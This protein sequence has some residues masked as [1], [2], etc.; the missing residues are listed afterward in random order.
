MKGLLYTILTIIILAVVGI[1][2]LGRQ[3]AEAPTAE[4][5]TTM[6]APVPGNE[7]VDEMVVD[8]TGEAMEDEHGP[9]MA[10]A[11]TFDISGKNFEFSQTEI[12]VKK[13]DTVRINFTSTEGLHDWEVDEFNAETAQVQTGQSSSVEFVADQAGEFE[14]YCSVGSH[15]AKGMVGKLIVE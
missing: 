4:G 9:A 3:D 14:Y 12:R 7:G 2:M 11:K 1:V 5:D 10:D 15:R 6:E 13:G 8:T